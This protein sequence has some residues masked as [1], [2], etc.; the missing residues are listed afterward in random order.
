MG[1]RSRIAVFALVTAGGA[2]FGAFCVL[3]MAA[4]PDPG[5]SISA[6]FL[7]GVLVLCGV[8]F[9]GAA[10][11]AVV[12]GLLAFLHRGEGARRVGP[13]AWYPDPVGRHR[14]RYWDG[15]VWTA[16]VADDGAAVE[17]PVGLGVSPP[18]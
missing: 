3:V 16:W 6:G 14:Q 15:S 8:V 9:V 4:D 12:A 18:G 7:T 11:T 2:V 1:T 17:D 13:A 5:T 10:L